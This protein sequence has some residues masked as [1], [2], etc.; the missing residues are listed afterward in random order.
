MLRGVDRAEAAE[1]LRAWARNPES[2]ALGVVA[3]TSDEAL[4]FAAAALQDD[5]VGEGETWNARTL[6][7]R[8]ADALRWA[9]GASADATSPLVVMATT[10]VASVDLL[11]SRSRLIV[12]L[13]AVAPL[14]RNAIA[15][16]DVPFSLIETDLE[17]AGLA[18]AD[19]ARVAY[20][21]GGKVS[22]L[23]RALGYSAPP[24]WTGRFD[25]AALQ[26]LLLIGAW[27]P[28]V[29]GDADAV[30]QF[31]AEP[32]ALERL[33]SA[34]QNSSDAPTVLEEG[35]RSNGIW[36][37]KSQ[38]DA[39]SQLIRNVDQP[40]L[41]R[42]Q[43]VA[44]SV[45]SAED[46]RLTLAPDERWRGA[47]FGKTL[48]YSGALRKGTATSL[49]RLAQ[50]DDA[51][52]LLHGE[53]A[54]SRTAAGVVHAVLRPG[55]KAWASVAELLPL[56]AEAAPS[57]FLDRIEESL[58]DGE[59]GVTQLL[60]Q[61]SMQVTPHTGVLWA[62]ETLGWH[63]RYAERVVHAL[64]ALAHEDAKI[65]KQHRVVNRPMRSLG[66]ILHFAFPQTTISSRQ[67]QSLL[68]SLAEK[69]PEVAFIFAC[70]DLRALR[71]GL[72]QT[73][74]RPEIARWPL[75]DEHERT[76]VPDFEARVR[77]SLEVALQTV[78]QNAERWSQLIELLNVLGVE[79]GLTVLTI[80]TDRRAEIQDDGQVIRRAIRKAQHLESRRSGDNLD[81]D[82]FV[83]QLQ[84]AAEAFTP[85]DPIERDAWLF[86]GPWIELS[87]SQEGFEETQR[88]I[89][90]LRL[91]TIQRL[92]GDTAEL[93]RLSRTVEDPGV[94]GA[95]IAR[96]EYGAALEVSLLD[97]SDEA[98]PALAVAGFIA[99][100]SRAEGDEWLRS[101]LL[102]ALRARGL[103][104]AVK[105]AGWISQS[106]SLWELLDQASPE[107]AAAF[108]TRSGPI[109][110]N[111]EP[112][113][114]E[115]VVHRFLA[116]E[117]GVSAFETLTGHVEKV[118][119]GLLL[120]VLEWFT[121]ESARLESLAAIGTVDYWLEQILTRLES[122]P[123]LD[124]GK[125]A[126]VELRLLPL[127]EFST[128][129]TRSF[130]A[131]MAQDV[132]FFIELLSAVYRADGD[133]PVEDSDGK[134]ER[135]ALGAYRVLESW[136]GYPGEGEPDQQRWLTLQRWAEAALHSSAEAK[137]VAVGALE[138][139][140]VL[141]RT[142]PDTD[143]HWPGKGV[144]DVLEA[145]TTRDLGKA[146]ALAKRN[147]RGVTSRAVGDG[148]DQERELQR[149]YALSAQTLRDRYPRTAQMLDSMADYY[150]A[151]A[152]EMDAE[153][154]TTR[155][156]YG[157]DRPVPTP[158]DPPQAGDLTT[159][160]LSAA[161]RSAVPIGGTRA[162]DSAVRVAFEPVLIE[163]IVV[164]NFRAILDLSL[165][166]KAPTEDRGQVT[167]MLGD[168][169]AGKS[170]F[171]RAVILALAGQHV[172]SAALSLMPAPLL[173][174]GRDRGKCVLSRADQGWSVELQRTHNVVTASCNPPHNDRIFVCG[175]GCDRGTL[176]ASP[177]GGDP[178]VPF[179][180][181]ATLFSSNAQM[182]SAIGWIK[183]LERRKSLDGGE[184]AHIFDAVVDVLRQLLPEEVTGLEVAKGEVF[185][186]GER[187]GGRVPLL[188]LS[189]GYLGT[190][191][192][193]SDLLCR[194]VTRAR[195][196]GVALDNR[197]PQAMRGL[198]VVD[199]VDMHLHPR[200]QRTIVNSIRQAFPRM[201]FLLTTHSPQT[202]L[203]AEPDEVVVLRWSG[204]PLSIHAM[205]VDIPRGIRTD[206]L[207]TG[208]WF[209][210][211]ATVDDETLQLMQDHQKLLLEHSDGVAEKKREL[212]DRLRQRLGSYA[213]TSLDR[214]AIETLA[215]VL[216][217]QHHP[218]TSE[219][220]EH[221]QQTLKARLKERLA[222]EPSEPVK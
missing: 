13:S 74:R 97:Q 58:G 85:S 167:L 59:A 8:D 138:V 34:L 56:L 160:G 199:E 106:R 131:A 146:I 41:R 165:D 129:P 148:G 18:R 162:N 171:L 173:S 204:E 174:N 116:A 150:G 187:I 69:R 87:E 137:R 109:Y 175:Y 102:R 216:R 147:L 2:E 176:L 62:L 96:S 91:S 169:G 128:A 21:S 5:T 36:A 189:D 118:A 123:Y 37:W 100:R 44:T 209:G 221:L 214:I 111:L 212:E 29:A 163:R 32:D 215:E 206:E 219:D 17:G 180:G 90:E 108:W 51:M 23:Q 130:S 142:P 222:K 82:A 19:A 25:A 80:L 115:Y 117:N 197:F 218:L 55:W 46:P 136:R 12:P 101:A 105:A 177:D 217:E 42:F 94:V 124:A 186:I 185:V 98:W 61:E 210:L 45:L 28:H 179:S 125:I 144:R 95:A 168:N 31:G 107:L 188:G 38:A 57:A 113:D 89:G 149:Q 195:S 152:L 190:I 77:F 24:D 33:C 79:L 70:K 14:P 135:L 22:A 207:L 30:K 112:D 104:V 93:L 201:S 153:A 49:A 99:Q 213:D 67:R 43:Q 205:K 143:G 145:Q 66:G 182:I 64:A 164:Q 192:W 72:L 78:Q 181:V 20:E 65:E 60:I 16:G 39:W 170:T 81:R 127:L 151:E 84:K 63:E 191:A 158:P 178:E 3:D 156:R 198:V 208:G 10:Q 155:R 15:L 6:V 211:S 119:P 92:N 40:T 193:V 48:Q 194:Y 200:W 133:P 184:H 196:A 1:R 35:H 172:A 86:G 157:M 4:C 53:G 159:D 140:K 154:N 120:E 166:L 73:S 27:N 47:L 103:D 141:A 68:Q 9:L 220:R 52:R 121:V 11:S 202:V 50:S 203:N 71:G 139:G 76:A 183:D 134:R 7:A 114:V 75:P 161:P 83:A 126:V 88:R 132:A 122:S 54:G 110:A 26:I